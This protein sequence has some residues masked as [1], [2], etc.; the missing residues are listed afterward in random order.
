MNAEKRK[1]I[2]GRILTLIS[3][4]DE[5]KQLGYEDQDI[6]N[7]LPSSLKGFYQD[8]VGAYSELLQ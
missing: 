4:L 7:A 6:D 5:L 8:M 1:R 2:K 3:K